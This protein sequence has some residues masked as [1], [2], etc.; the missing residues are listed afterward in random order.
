MTQR[1]V[2]PVLS[3][4][5]VAS[6]VSLLFRTKRVSEIRAYEKQ[7]RNE[8]D[9]K[10][11][12]LRDLLGTRYRDLLRAADEMNAMRD[13]SVEKVRDSL[14]DVATKATVLRDHFEKQASITPATAG[15]DLER[16]KGVHEIGG[17]LKHIVDSPEVLYACLE[18]GEVYNAAKRF[19]LA[20]THYR[21]VTETSG[22]EGVANRF[23]ERRW[24]EVQ[25]F[26]VQILS[27]AEKRLVTPGLKSQ[28]Y[29]EMLASLIVLT[30]EPD[31]VSLLNGM[32]AARTGWVDDEY[33]AAVGVAEQ[34]CAI[35][36]VVRSTVSCAS[37]IFWR[38]CIDELLRGIDDNA[39]DLINN[40]RKDGSLYEAL[41]SWTTGVKAW[42]DDKGPG[43]LEA[44][45]SSGALAD[46]LRALDS[47]F[48]VER[49]EEDC[50]SALDQPPS[51]VFDIFV[52]FISNR[53]S[54]VAS[55]CIENA[56]GKVLSDID[57]AWAEFDTA[58]HAGNL[59]WSVVSNQT[60]GME[61]MDQ[62][63]GKDSFVIDD[64]DLSRIL[65]SHGQV[66][67]VVGT[68][69]SSLKRAL[70][71]AAVLTK[72]IPSVSDSFIKSV[73]CFLPQV[74]SKLE[75]KLG[76]LANDSSQT[77]EPCELLME[78]ALFVARAGSSLGNAESVKLAH[79]FASNEAMGNSNNEALTQFQETAA[80]LS[81]SGYESWANRLCAQLQKQ[82]L[83]NLTSELILSVPMGWTTGQ[84]SHDGED[85]TDSDVLR[86]PTTASSALVNF[87]MEACSFAN[88]AGGFALPGNAIQ[89]LREEMM[90][91]MDETYTAALDV[92][93]GGSS[94]EQSEG[95]TSTAARRSGTSDVAVMQ[96][97]FDILVLQHF[98]TESPSYSNSPSGKPMKALESNIRSFVD[99]IDLAACK[100]ALEKS[101]SSY[102]VRTEI[103]FGTVI[104]SHGKQS[105][106]KA[107][108]N[109]SATANLVALSRSVPRFT[110][111]PAPM[112]STYSTAGVST[113]GLN[114]K[115][116]IEMLRTETSTANGSSSYRTR[117]SDISVAGYASKVSES[118]GRFGRG[119]LESLTR[120]VG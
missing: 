114:A 104:Q 42:L 56:V 45:S 40:A 75:D 61:P 59:L 120:N 26:K 6:E 89:F 25:V 92:Y 9:D 88:R 53:A 66:S 109:L 80:K 13:A 58:P 18:S 112:P 116:A 38:D 28:E 74:L 14:R 21:E 33:R 107:L 37:D 84:D 3:T 86:Y 62:K 118:V 35:A 110:Y 52:P 32:L 65:S 70:E 83:S 101:V 68:F 98:F 85:H 47:V 4:G 16:R 90:S 64:I 50:R 111:L 51:F 11:D 102:A 23:A 91:A 81:A 93:T 99:P 73:R 100:T 27:A 69:E 41:R 96:L 34:L 43:I 78:K 72:R 36:T 31:L 103:L 106:A 67:G 113:A 8:A 82:L 29:A 105:T 49:W 63:K 19:S 20:S 94:A 60:V 108:T 48:E 55:D 95:N 79:C 2:T 30:E 115:A 77:T 54:V 15:G 22:L 97:L 1:P 71:D 119:F 76:T 12:S 39:L 24:K 87:M 17:K 117:E 57:E 44:A 10:S 7:I 46:T 5:S